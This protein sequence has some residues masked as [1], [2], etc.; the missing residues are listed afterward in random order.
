MQQ[1]SKTRFIHTIC[2]SLSLLVLGSSVPSWAAASH[3]HRKAQQTSVFR[4]PPPGLG[5]KPYKMP[6]RRLGNP[7]PIQIPEKPSL[8]RRPLKPPQDGSLIPLP[9]PRPY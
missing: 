3:A 8:P 1:P 6:R 4:V 9:V 2:V 7:P 5:P